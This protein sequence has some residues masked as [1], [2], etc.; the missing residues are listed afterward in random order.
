MIP[1]FATNHATAPCNS[2]AARAPDTPR[3]D[4]LRAT[5]PAD[6]R[7]IDGPR[8]RPGQRALSVPARPDC[9]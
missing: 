4:A 1:C 9:D 7:D 8:E 3:W 6:A 2:A 5:T